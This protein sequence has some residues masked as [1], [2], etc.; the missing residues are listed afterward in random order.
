M[1]SNN[2]NDPII[3]VTNLG[4]KYKIGE[5]EKYLALRDKLVDSVRTPYRLIKGE[6]SLK[7]PEI[8]ALKNLSFKVKKGEVVGIIGRNGAG[9]TTLLKIL[10]RIT[11]PTTGEVVIKGRVGS[12]LEVGTG[13]HPELTGRE[14]IY[15]NGS[16]LGM[17]KKE[18]NSR[19]D[20]IVEFSGIEQFL[21][22][23]VK[24]YSS[25]MYVRLAFSVAA[26]LE[27]E[28]LL[29]D[30]VL[31]VGDAEFQKKCLGKM[32]DVAKGGR[33]VLFVS[34]NMDA[35]RQ[36]C[37]RTILISKG[38]IDLDDTSNSVVDAYYNIDDKHNLGVKKYDK[39]FAPGDQYVKLNLIRMTNDTNI[40]TTKFR[41]SENI[42][43]DIF[44]EV[45]ET[46]SNFHLYIKV[47]TKEGITAFCS[48]DWDNN[49]NIFYKLKPGK[50]FVRC[51]IP[52]NLLN[53]GEYILTIM[54]Q[55]PGVR[56]VFVEDGI[57]SWKVIEIDGSGGA[58]SVNRPGIFRPKLKWYLKPIK[59]N[60]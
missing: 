21:D 51:I 25:G 45:L 60:E 20:D 36:L 12:L 2:E 32:K 9:K 54:G 27:S 49:K 58:I 19:F 16:I 15:L 33:T 47:L 28:I 48:G 52:G 42:L 8:W 59:N 43:I 37:S 53:K 29:I 35:I 40:A 4:K 41:I 6:T 5:K 1:S 57:L 44:F 34:H 10:S 14:N 23:P 55:I 22:T 38:I 39:N 26:H 24:R 31:A 13:F 46:I 7:K 11:E 18:I 30:E 3:K 50:F 56:Y 17:T